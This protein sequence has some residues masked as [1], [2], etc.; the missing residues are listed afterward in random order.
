MEL[1]EAVKNLIS[2][3]E[4]KGYQAYLAGGCVRDFLLGKVPHDYDL[5]TDAVPDEI[6]SI[7]EDYHTLGVGKAFGTILVVTEIGNVEITT[8][9]ADGTYSDGRKPD[10][11]YFSKSLEEDVKRRDFTINAMAYSEKCG[12]I[13]FFGGKSDL[14]KKIIRTVGDPYERF[15]EDNLRMLRAVRFATTLSFE[16]ESETMSVI[17]KLHEKLSGISRERIREEWIKIITSE[18]P[19]RGLFLLRD[20]GLSKIVFPDFDLWANENSESLE[21]LYCDLDRGPKTYLHR[22]LIFF[23]A[24]KSMKDLEGIRPTVNE[25]SLLKQLLDFTYPEIINSF[26]VKKLMAGLTLDNLRYILDVKCFLEGE[27]SNAKKARVI[28]ERVLSDGEP[29]S[30]GDL[31]ING[32]DVIERGF[33]EG[34]AVGEILEKVLLKVLETPSLNEREVLLNYIDKCGREYE[35]IFRN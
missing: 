22:M 4:E 30:I 18:N 20:S 1:P 25:R 27:D 10:S 23:H 5:T 8:F 16:I 15:K 6:E 35:Q 17:K 11:V 31:S 2:R 32:K 29:Y 28:M 33:P 9:R 24:A 34:R 3:L 13:D 21:K 7:F 14:E 26:Y 12:L 19:S